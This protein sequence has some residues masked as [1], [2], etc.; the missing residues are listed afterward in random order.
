MVE[1][2]SVYISPS[3]V[4]QESSHE[5]ICTAYEWSA[6][7]LWC[8]LYFIADFKKKAILYESE[9][10]LETLKM[11]FFWEVGGWVLLLVPADLLWR[12]QGF[13]ICPRGLLSCHPRI[14]QFTGQIDL[15]TP[16]KIKS[17][18]EPADLPQCTYQING[19]VNVDMSGFSVA[20]CLGPRPRRYRSIREL[21]LCEMG[22]VL[23]IYLITH[24]FQE[25]LAKLFVSSP[26]LCTQQNKQDIRLLTEYRRWY[27][28]YIRCRSR[29][30][31]LAN[32]WW[33]LSW[34]C[35]KTQKN[36]SLRFFGHC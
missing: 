36:H 18:C 16:I 6:S 9:K 29:W 7:W 19:S 17:Q 25:L 32:K 27:L 2:H 34:Y 23:W 35:Q 8:S 3:A 15:V 4:I 31:M 26:C 28:L 20:L 5:C 14:V 24:S 21:C 13:G 12:V 11:W 1:L 10:C 22:P 33:I 30:L